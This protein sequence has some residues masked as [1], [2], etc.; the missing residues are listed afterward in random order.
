MMIFKRQQAEEYKG[1]DKT[2]T[3]IIK[4]KSGSEYYVQFHTYTHAHTHR[5]AYQHPQTQLGGAK[6]ELNSLIGISTFTL[7]YFVLFFYFWLRWG[8]VPVHG[9]SLVVASGG[10]LLVAVH[11]LLIAVASLVVE[12]GL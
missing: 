5:S 2:F 9:L 4:G 7:F 8:F 6:Y 11:G 3:F 10:L 12:H 1:H